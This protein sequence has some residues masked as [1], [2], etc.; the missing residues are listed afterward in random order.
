MN[1]QRLILS[2]ALLGGVLST[3][4]FATTADA[5]ARVTQAAFE[6]PAI[7]TVV[8]PT[9]LSRRLEGATVIL[10]M[11]IDANGQP[12]NIRVTSSEDRK[13][14]ERLVAAVSQWHF[15]PAKKNGVAVPSKV[16]L[17]VELVAS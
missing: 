6:A 14:S 17:P 9:G 1:L 8:A 11:T 2:A 4:A 5:H 16:V 12:G 15:T 3:S 10:S 13:N 7:A